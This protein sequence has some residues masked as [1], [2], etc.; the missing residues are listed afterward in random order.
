MLLTGFLRGFNFL[1]N[2]LK[3]AWVPGGL[4]NALFV[5]LSTFP[6]LVQSCF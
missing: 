4:W 5:P 2:I 3:T 6:S 1:Q